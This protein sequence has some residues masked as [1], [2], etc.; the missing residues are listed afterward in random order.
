MNLGQQ[1]QT[2]KMTDE[3]L[4]RLIYQT[5]QEHFPEKTA[6]FDKFLQ[7]QAAKYG[8]EYAKL[9]A[10]AGTATLL[11]APLFWLGVGIVGAMLMRR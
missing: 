6:E 4:F 7:E 1:Q 10:E 9:K 11:R 8:V 2:Q 3:E 5:A